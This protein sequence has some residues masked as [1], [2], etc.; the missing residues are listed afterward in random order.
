MCMI[1]MKKKKNLQRS[2]EY[3]ENMSK[4]EAKVTEIFSGFF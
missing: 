1:F 2:P 4:I 3:E